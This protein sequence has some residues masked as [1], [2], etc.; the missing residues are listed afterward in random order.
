MVGIGT[1]VL[2]Y[3]DPDI[4]RAAIKAINSSSMNTLN[5][6]EDIELAELLIKLHPWAIALGMPEQGGN[7]VYSNQ[8]CSSFYR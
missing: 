3:C 8:N 2:G 6:P 5:P 1:S 7:N 4:N